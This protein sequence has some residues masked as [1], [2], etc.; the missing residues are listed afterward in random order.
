MLSG[1]HK[2][3]GGENSKRTTWTSLVYGVYRK[4]SNQKEAKAGEEPEAVQKMREIQRINVL[5]GNRSRKGHGEGQ[6][7]PQ[8]SHVQ[9]V[10]QKVHLNAA[11]KISYKKTCGDTKIGLKRA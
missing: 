7:R 4:R 1:E 10:P 5:S 11:K 3:T 8:R 2:A 9:C 6:A